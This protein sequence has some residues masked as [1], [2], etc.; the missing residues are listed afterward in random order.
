[1]VEPAP[2]PQVWPHEKNMTPS[3]THGPPAQS[4]GRLLQRCQRSRFGD[5]IDAV[6]IGVDLHA[7]VEGPASPAKT[8]RWFQLWII[9]EV[10][11]ALVHAGDRSA[12]TIA[13]RAETT[14]ADMM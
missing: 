4:A 12:I 7:Q 6:V 2:L 9:D 5:V 3:R 14:G 1:M 10:G 8:E 13:V 11:V